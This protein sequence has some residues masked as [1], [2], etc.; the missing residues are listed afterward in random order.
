M[1]NSNLGT[2]LDYGFQVFLFSRER[3][4]ENMCQCQCLR[5]AAN[6]QCVHRLRV[7][8]IEF[9]EF[10]NLKHGLGFPSSER[11]GSTLASLLCGFKVEMPVVLLSLDLIK[12][13]IIKANDSHILRFFMHPSP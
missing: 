5:E 2:P 11:S 9:F 6:C 1:V 3:S 8:D 7:F 4:R 13:S 10:M 12:P